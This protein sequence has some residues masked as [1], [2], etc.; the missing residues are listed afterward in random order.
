MQK[1]TYCVISFI[2][3]VI[4]GKEKPMMVWGALVHIAFLV[5]S[6]FLTFRLASLKWPLKWRPGMKKMWVG[7]TVAILAP[8]LQQ[9][10]LLTTVEQRERQKGE[11][12]PRGDLEN[13][14]YLLGKL[15][16]ERILHS[17]EVPLLHS[18][19]SQ[20]LLGPHLNLPTPTPTIS[21]SAWAPM[22]SSVKTNKGNLLQNGT[23]KPQRG[24]YL[25]PPLMERSELAELRR[26]EDFLPAQQQQAALPC[27]H[28]KCSFSSSGFV[29]K[30]T[31]SS[32]LLSSIK[33]H[34]PL[35]FSVLAY[36]LPS[37][38]RPERHLLC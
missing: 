25:A 38:G 6:P 33:G 14:T 7:W 24:G 37:F 32:F 36:G 21:V 4:F 18:L 2:W 17:S 26:K 35:L 12:K 20:P 19:P 9:T 13:R 10:T 29:F 5:P 23:G 16:S 8:L 28:V 3:K 31:P 27:N 22:L 15:P 11:S 34:S 1:A 30:T